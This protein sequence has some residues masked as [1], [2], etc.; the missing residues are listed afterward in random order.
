MFDCDVT[1]VC[2]LGRKKEEEEEEEEE[3]E[4]EKGGLSCSSS[5]TSL[6]ETSLEITASTLS[7]IEWLQS[8]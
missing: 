5:K 1:R 3:K 7:Y 6:K 2:C 4:E 8:L